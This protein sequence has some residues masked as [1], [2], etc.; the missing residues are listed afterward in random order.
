MESHQVGVKAVIQNPL[1]KFLIVR[2]KERWQA[3]G[4]RLEA[5]ERLEE[6]LRREAAEETGLTNLQVGK[7]VHVDEWFSKPE[8]ELKHIVALF[9][10]CQTV[11]D[12]V[13]LSAEHEAYAWVTPDELESYGDTIEKE[14][15]QAIILASLAA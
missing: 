5:G 9:F 3:V 8:G 12:E 11:T 10:L 7:I 15:S 1:G 14:I 13:T 2:E 4:G 6:G